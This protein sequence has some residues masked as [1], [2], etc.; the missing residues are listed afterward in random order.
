[1]VSS[2]IEVRKTDWIIDDIKSPVMKPY[3]GGPSP[4]VSKLGQVVITF[5]GVVSDLYGVDDP[6]Q[7]TYRPQI[8]NKRFP[9][10]IIEDRHPSLSHEGVTFFASNQETGEADIATKSVMF[11]LTNLKEPLELQKRNEWFLIRGL[12]PFRPSNKESL[13]M[14]VRSLSDVMRYSS[15]F[16]GRELLGKDRENAIM[17]FPRLRPTIKRIRV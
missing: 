13:T 5:E 4:P 3:T 10:P 9:K 7:V 6:L 12:E 16:G 14:S 17:W 11:N 2:P 8:R 1:M 15:R